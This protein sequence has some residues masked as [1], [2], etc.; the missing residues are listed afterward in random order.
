MVVFI[1]VLIV[2]LGIY[3]LSKNGRFE[4][5]DV[6]V[7]NY[8]YL[9]HFDERSDVLLPSTSGDFRVE[10]QSN[11]RLI[12]H[13]FKQKETYMIIQQLREDETIYFICVRNNV[14]TKI[15][16]DNDFI[17]IHDSYAAQK[18]RILLKS[19]SEINNS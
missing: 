1:F 4:I 7:Y 2:A 16:L 10:W 12:I 13:I 5:V 15:I 8:Y 3:Y 18:G 11:K 9:S 6:K 19:M 17:A 14:K